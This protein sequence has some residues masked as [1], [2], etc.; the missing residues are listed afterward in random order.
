MSTFS[1]NETYTIANQP[2]RF[3]T[4]KIEGNQRMLDIDSVYD[5]TFLASKRVLV[6]G[7]NRGIGLALCKELNSKGCICHC[8]LP[9]DQS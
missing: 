8:H 9:T 6:T 3:A 4:A 5:G 1:N 2:L 7:G